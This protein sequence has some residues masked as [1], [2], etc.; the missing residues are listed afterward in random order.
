MN[1]GSNLVLTCVVDTGPL[2]PQYI[3]WYKEDQIIAYS[4]DIKAKVYTTMAKNGTGRPHQSEMV[5]RNVSARDSGNYRCNSDLTDEARI[6]VYVVEEDL[7][8]LHSD[9]AA[10]GTKKQQKDQ[11]SSAVAVASGAARTTSL[12]PC[13][14]SFVLVHASTTFVLL[15][16]K[17]LSS[18]PRGLS[19]PRSHGLLVFTG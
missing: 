10:S 17:T 1:I 13:L 8:S 15:L 2:I 5:I 12:W 6:T 16:R 14:M 4:E 11:V 7:K 18:S 3:L 19:S 9:T